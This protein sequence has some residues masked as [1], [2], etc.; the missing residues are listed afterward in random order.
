MNLPQIKP[1]N[2]PETQ[3]RIHKILWFRLCIY[4][5]FVQCQKVPFDSKLAIEIE[6]YRYWIVSKGDR[7]RVLVWPSIINRFRLE[8]V[9]RELAGARS[10]AK[11]LDLRAHN[12]IQ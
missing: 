5:R 10:R 4:R 8:S 7:V 6:A 2:H 3:T 11:R 12:Q 1:I 9:S